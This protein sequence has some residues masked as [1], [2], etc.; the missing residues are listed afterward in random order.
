MAREGI[1]FRGKGLKTDKWFY[2][3]FVKSY[4]KNKNGDSLIVDDDGHY[5]NVRGDT[6]GEFIGRRDIDG[7]EIYEGDKVLVEDIK[8]EGIVKYNEVYCEWYIEFGEGTTLD[9]G[10][11]ALMN[12]KV[13]VL[14]NVYEETEVLKK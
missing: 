11:I 6:I 12:Y 14:G 13:K 7:K 9:F 4:K 2:G 5:H 8:K 10:M 1:K 3:Y